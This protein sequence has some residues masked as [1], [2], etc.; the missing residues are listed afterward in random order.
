MHGRV[1]HWRMALLDYCL[2]LGRFASI[3]SSVQAPCLNLPWLE[4]TRHVS[5]IRRSA[6]AVSSRGTRIVYAE[7]LGLS[8]EIRS[9]PKSWNLHLPIQRERFD[10]L[11][12]ALAHASVLA[13]PIVNNM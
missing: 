8:C 12:S 1:A 11:N 10:F 3:F 5:L 2:L 4:S 13:V 6:M 9:R 7:F